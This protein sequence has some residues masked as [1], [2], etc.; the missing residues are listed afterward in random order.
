M[1]SPI[2]ALVRGYLIDPKAKTITRVSFP[3]DGEHLPHMYRLIECNYVEVVRLPGD[4]DCW[5]DEEGTFKPDDQ[6]HYF[7][8]HL[9]GGHWHTV[10]GR[11]LILGC[12]G[13][14][15]VSATIDEAVLLGSVRFYNPRAGSEQA[16]RASASR[17]ER[18]EG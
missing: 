12:D 9:G 10:V 14:E 4:N 16:A 17:P 13:P 3:E 8:I 11:G 6:L 7:A 18:I 2:H 5:C 15:T 1:P